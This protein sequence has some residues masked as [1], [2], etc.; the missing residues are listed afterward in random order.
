MKETSKEQLLHKECTI[1]LRIYSGK[2]FRYNLYPKGYHNHEPT[3]LEQRLEQDSG[4]LHPEA[5]MQQSA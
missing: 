1:L 2:A 5:F 4:C 3:R